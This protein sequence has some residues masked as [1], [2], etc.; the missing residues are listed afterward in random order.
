MGSWELKLAKKKLPI[1]EQSDWHL[2]T[3]LAY[4]CCV[5]KPLVGAM[6]VY[7]FLG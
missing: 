2:V 7:H 4:P 1:E 3:H 6:M 5:W